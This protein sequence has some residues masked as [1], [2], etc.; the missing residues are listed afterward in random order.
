MPVRSSR[1]RAWAGAQFA[2]VDDDDVRA[3]LLDQAAQLVDLSP[4]R[5]VRRIGMTPGL[6]EPSDDPQP[7]RVGEP[8]QLGKWLRVGVPARSPSVP[9]P[10]AVAPQRQQDGA[11]FTVGP[12]PA[13][14]GPAPV[15]QQPV[16]GR[17]AQGRGYWSC[18]SVSSETS[19]FE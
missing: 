16:P 11:V 19:K 4:A 17:P 8:G 6:G 2:V 14:V 12:L 15:S 13:A 18:S 5:V 9:V 1:L 3:L 7:V 10:V